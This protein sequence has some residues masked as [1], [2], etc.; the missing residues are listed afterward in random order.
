MVWPYYSMAP[1]PG[2]RAPALLGPLV[3][4]QGGRAPTI[5]LGILPGAA[6]VVKDADPYIVYCIEEP[7]AAV[8]DRDLVA[9]VAA[10][11]FALGELP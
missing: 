5:R 2:G 9:E 6:R 7:K 11:D 8:R 3:G 1:G 4:E 10:P